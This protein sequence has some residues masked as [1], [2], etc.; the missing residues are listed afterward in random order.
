[1]VAGVV[2]VVGGRGLQKGLLRVLHFLQLMHHKM[3]YE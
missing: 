1:M 2:V 3:L